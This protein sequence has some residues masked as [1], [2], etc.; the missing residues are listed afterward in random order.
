MA[1]VVTALTSSFAT[2][3]IPAEAEV[4]LNPLEKLRRYRV[5][6]LK[7]ILNCVILVLLLTYTFGFHTQRTRH[8]RNARFG[9]TRQFYDVVSNTDPSL[10]SRFSTIDEVLAFVGQIGKNYFTIPERS[11]GVYM[12]Y[13]RSATDLTPLPPRFFVR[14]LRDGIHGLRSSFTD[15][16]TVDRTEFMNESN[17]YLGPLFDPEA[18]LDNVTRSSCVPAGNP[19]YIPCRN[20]TAAVLFDRLVYGVITL[21]LRSVEFY[22]ETD[23][24]A[25]P[26]VV[27]WDVLIRLSPDAHGSEI[28]VE[29]QF[30]VLRTTSWDKVAVITTGLLLPLCLWNFLLHLR[31]FQMYHIYIRHLLPKWTH[32]GNSRQLRER[33]AGTSWKVFAMTC[34]AT[35][36]TFCMLSLAEQ[37]ETL[38]SKSVRTWRTVFLGFAVFFY[39]NLFLSYLQTSPHFYVLVKTMSVGSLRIGT[40]VISVLPIYFG[41]ATTATVILGPWAQ[42]TF[43]NV[44]QSC[45]TLFAMLNGDSL[46]QL[47]TQA[48]RTNF[49]LQ[50]LSSKLF[51]MFFLGYGI[52]VALNIM[53][54]II[55]DALQHVRRVLEV[56]QFDVDAANRELDMQSQRLTA[57]EKRRRKLQLRRSKLDQ[58]ATGSTT[59]EEASTSSSDSDPEAAVP[60]DPHQL[61]RLARRVG[62]ITQLPSDGSMSTL[63]TPRKASA[64]VPVR[65]ASRNVSYN[66]SHGADRRASDSHSARVRFHD[67]LEAA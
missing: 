23:P 64:A 35:C 60:L 11:P 50:R 25:T 33:H 54:G 59:E 26:S 57:A 3:A 6:P 47:F 46:L 27:R 34:D 55:G 48:N 24:L 56:V 38:Q 4:L 15:A 65:E 13:V 31:S 41:F 51:M 32:L 10:T 43:G 16:M 29:A 12:H 37:L 5:F 8:E 53:L 17:A 28:V 40:Y 21:H 20:N 45:I 44:Q 19:P 49:E 36:F 42:D 22:D 63:T 61:R 62:K 58:Y 7:F 66:A 18:L 1:P 14:V 9:L 52:N 39:T 2:K 67:T 30:R